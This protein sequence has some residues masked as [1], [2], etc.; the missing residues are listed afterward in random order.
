MWSKLWSL[1]HRN[2]TSNEY[3]GLISFRIDWF[4]LPAVQDT[5][6][7]LPCR[8]VLKHQFFGL[9]TFLDVYMKEQRFDTLG[10]CWPSLHIVKHFLFLDLS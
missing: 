10:I 9:L 5:L 1:R 8:I 3:A 2:T 7:S 6:T 4:D